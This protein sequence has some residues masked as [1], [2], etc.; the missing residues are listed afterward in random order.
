MSSHRSLILS[1]FWWRGCIISAPF[2]LWPSDSGPA[3]P[4]LSHTAAWCGRPSW[5][6]LHSYFSLSL[7]LLWMQFCLSFLFL[8][9]LYFQQRNTGLASVLH[10]HA[11]AAVWIVLSPLAEPGLH[12]M[13]MEGPWELGLESTVLLRVNVLR[14]AISW[15]SAG[16]IAAGGEPVV[17]QRTQGSHT[18]LPLSSGGMGIG[19]CQVSSPAGR[20]LTVF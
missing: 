16:S 3:D 15:S 8:V 1:L 9:L 11:P 7:A 6:L 10:S 17:G 18:Q 5:E 13:A 12:T 2:S 4:A 14:Q 19:L 20:T